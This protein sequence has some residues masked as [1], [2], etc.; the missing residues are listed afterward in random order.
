MSKMRLNERNNQFLKK[1][2]VDSDQRK[3]DSNQMPYDSNQAIK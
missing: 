2:S 3:H 1:M